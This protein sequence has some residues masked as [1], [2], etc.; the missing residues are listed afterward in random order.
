MKIQ[1]QIF[2]YV[3]RDSLTYFAT[4]WRAKIFVICKETAPSSAEKNCLRSTS[5]KYFESFLI[6]EKL[7]SED[8][9]S[10]WLESEASSDYRLVT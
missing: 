7:L 6:S 4:L 2:R 5:Y 9:V 3:Q 8:D 1:R 10:F